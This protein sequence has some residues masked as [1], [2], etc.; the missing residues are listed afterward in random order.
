MRCDQVDDLLSWVAELQEEAE[1]LRSIRESEKDIDW[2]NYAL[3]SLRQ[4]QEHPPEK[5]RR[6]RGFCIL[7]PPGR[8]Q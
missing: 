6:S 8:R 4:K 7:P 2:W 3:P 1:R 5:D